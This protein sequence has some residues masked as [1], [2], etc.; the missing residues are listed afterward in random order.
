M[1]ARAVPSAL[2]LFERSHQ[3]YVRE[4]QRTEHPL[5]A[6]DRPPGPVEVRRAVTTIDRAVNDYVTGARLEKLRLE[7]V[8]TFK[9]AG[10]N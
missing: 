10:P 7:P 4:G 6:A 1:P 8:T 5:L 2:R 9:H 3:P